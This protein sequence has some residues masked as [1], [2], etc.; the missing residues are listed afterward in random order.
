MEE[1]KVLV[2]DDE[3][4]ARG[5]LKYELSSIPNVKIMGECANGKEVLAY[6]KAHPN[7]DI[8]FLD[9]EMPIMNGLE[10][11][12]EILKMD[13]PLKIVFATGYS[14]FALQAFDLEAF[15]YILKPYS[16]TRIRRTI[17]RLR[18]SL[19]LR[20]SDTVPGEVTV[21]SQKV[22]IQTKDKT[23]MI[24]PSREIVLVS[25]EKSDRSLFYTTGGIVESRMTLRDIESL[26]TPL[27]F[28][29]T[30][31]GYIV[32]LSMIHEIQP[33]DN[34]T[35]LLTMTRYEKQKVPVSRHYI[36]AFK[37]QLHL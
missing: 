26:L 31:K 15:D 16:E 25:T 12:G 3:L 6:L 18:D 13:L 23:L 9:I 20:R 36:K 30:H 22:S 11:A 29:R 1:I 17:E 8:L 14:Q 4:P 35:L 33:Q 28:F 24:S 34:G 32:N 27:G 10:C 7:V 19:S 5:E 21:Y 2:A 37:E